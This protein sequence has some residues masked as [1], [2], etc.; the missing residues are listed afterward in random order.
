MSVVTLCISYFS[1]EEEFNPYDAMKRLRMAESMHVNFPPA[2]ENYFQQ[3]IGYNCTYH[4]NV[5][6]MATDGPSIIHIA[7]PELSFSPSRVYVENMLFATPSRHHE[8]DEEVQNKQ[9]S[10]FWYIC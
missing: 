7:T 9:R 4:H 2:V 8:V 3:R 1:D 5:C 6:T 10:L